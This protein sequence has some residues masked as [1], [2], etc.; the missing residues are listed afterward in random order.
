MFLSNE[1][2]YSLDISMYKEDTD[3]V[4]SQVTFRAFGNK[5]GPL[6]GLLVSTP[7]MTKVRQ[8]LVSMPYMT[9]V[10]QLLVSMP[11]MTKVRQSLLSKAHIKKIR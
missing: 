8:L 11:Y 4:T 5:S 10:R 3:P 6:N 1:N 2:G 7:Y 9:K